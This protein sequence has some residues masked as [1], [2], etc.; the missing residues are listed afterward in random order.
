MQISVSFV[1]WKRM[2]REREKRRI[3]SGFKVQLVLIE[4][5]LSRSRGK[6]PPHTV[7]RW[8]REEHGDGIARGREER[9]YHLSSSSSQVIGVLTLSRFFTFFFPQFIDQCSRSISF[10]DWKFFAIK[11]NR[12]FLSLHPFPSASASSS[13]IH[14]KH[15]SIRKFFQPENLI[16]KLFLKQEPFF[17]RAHNQLPLP[18]LLL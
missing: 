10:P 6:S 9:C 1:I 3:A 16:V 14:P 8:K 11:W 7:G 17:V 5:G 18:P 12:N 4:L 15:H 13:S 2:E